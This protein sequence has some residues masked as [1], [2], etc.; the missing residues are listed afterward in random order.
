MLRPGC[1]K[2]SIRSYVKAGLTGQ[3]DTNWT[4]DYW[5]GS[6]GSYTPSSAFI[7][8]APLRGDVLK[9]AVDGN[10]DVYV[11]GPRLANASGD[12][13]NL[14]KYSGINGHE[15]WKVDIATT[16]DAGN[17]W[18]VIWA[19]WDPSVVHVHGDVD[20]PANTT[21]SFRINTN[22]GSVASAYSTGQTGY[23]L[24]DTDN[25]IVQPA[26]LQIAISNG[27]SA[28]PYYQA[29]AS[30]RY[31]TLANNASAFDDSHPQ[32]ILT[33]LPDSGTAYQLWYLQG[34]SAWP[35][36]TPYAVDLIDGGTAQLLAASGSPIYIQTSP[37]ITG[38]LVLLDTGLDAGLTP[39]GGSG[40]P[41]TYR[42][43]D[44][45]NH[46]RN[47]CKFQDTTYLITG[48]NGTPTVE[49]LLVSDGSTSWAHIHLQP[50]GI[51][52][53]SD[54]IITVGTR[55]SKITDVDFV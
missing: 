13:W 18:D 24:L 35:H 17:L 29:I 11:C 32:L 16:G 49:A 34:T 8:A 42:W 33:D 19:D 51:A 20:T 23:L 53:S 9:V 26:P 1:C 40:F 44:P 37:L 28:F 7:A 30:S 12:H 21:L 54:A 48:A 25:S 55:K 27:P 6:T 43:F 5:R 38:S 41:F 50:T 31:A 22:D 39:S 4:A 2:Y 36:G 46:P 10:D 14:I 45:A 52:I 3:G 15:V 47:V